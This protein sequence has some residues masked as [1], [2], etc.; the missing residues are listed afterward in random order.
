VNGTIEISQSSETFA[1]LRDQIARAT[2]EEFGHIPVIRETVWANADW[3]IAF[4]SDG[5]AL[6]FLSIV[7]RHA[8]FDDEIV[9]VAGISNVITRKPHRHRGLGTLIMRKAQEM[10]SSCLQADFGLL[11]CSEDVIP[12]YARLGWVKARAELTFDQ[13]AGARA[14]PKDV[15]I[16]FPGG[17]PFTFKNIDLKGLP[18]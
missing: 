4:V 17:N 3:H 12:F 7:E 6:S 9:K 13:P 8:S 1:P 18:W 2:F 10:M 11:L 5:E 16:Y 15:L 14:W